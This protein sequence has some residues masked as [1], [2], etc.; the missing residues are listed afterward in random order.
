MKDTNEAGP[1]ELPGP[2]R[3]CYIAISFGQGKQQ[4]GP[5]KRTARRLARKESTRRS[6]LAHTTT[7]TRRAT[8]MATAAPGEG[9]EVLTLYLRAY[10][11]SALPSLDGEPE[12]EREPE[13]ELPEDVALWLPSVDPDSLLA[14][15]LLAAAFPPR[16]RERNASAETRAE[17]QAEPQPQ[18]AIAWRLASSAALPREERSAAPLLVSSRRTTAVSG[19]GP[20][21]DLLSP[22]LPP[23]STST[24]TS[25]SATP[26]TPVS[27]TDAA[28]RAYLQRQLAPLVQHA[29]Y[30]IPVTF[31]E[32]VLPAYKGAYDAS[33]APPAPASAGEGA[34]TGA[35]AGIRR[36]LARRARTAAAVTEVI[37]L[38]TQLAPALALAG[39]PTPDEETA[40]ATTA[41]SSLRSTGAYSSTK[42]ALPSAGSDV[43]AASTTVT[44]RGM[45]ADDTS[46]TAHCFRQAQVRSSFHSF[47][48]LSFP[49]ALYSRS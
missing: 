4:S 17:A 25:L 6:A 24:S 12:H 23:T 40:A 30:A 26:A 47:P 45:N 9:P 11:P 18:E 34:S 20:I 15:S 10:I 3:S 36:W 38:R 41:A 5:A 8:T 32:R 21:W 1:A 27:A 43:F 33:M 7:I 19:I 35:G 22:L 31:N 44:E 42:T 13:L 14:A 49:S 28:L 37:R 16:K 39:L 2:P 46:A 48:P 29:L